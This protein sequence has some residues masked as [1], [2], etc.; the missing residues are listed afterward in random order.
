M[1]VMD[2]DDVRFIFLFSRFILK[3]EVKLSQGSYAITFK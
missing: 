2:G 1:V 3:L